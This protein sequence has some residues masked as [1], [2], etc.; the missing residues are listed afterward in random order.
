MNNLKVGERVRVTAGI[1]SFE[2]RTGRIIHIIEPGATNAG[3]KA[4]ALLEMPLY[5]VRFD[6]GRSF[7]FRGRDLRSLMVLAQVAVIR[8]NSN[9]R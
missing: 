9:L 2:S 6:D 5:S 8:S 7:R 4:E 1:P 3:R